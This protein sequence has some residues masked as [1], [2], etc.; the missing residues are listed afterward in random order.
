MTM[1]LR[2]R[3]GSHAWERFKVY[4]RTLEEQGEWKLR[5]RR[6]VERMGLDDPPDTRD[7]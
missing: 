5:C 1:R 4:D 2:C 6:C 3:L 7:R